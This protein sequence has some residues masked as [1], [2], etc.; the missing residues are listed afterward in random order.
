MYV[1]IVRAIGVEVA[2][3]IAAAG[4]R[5]GHGKS[6]AAHRKLSQEQVVG[7]GRG[8]DATLYHREAA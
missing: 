1:S 2:A 5:C 6:K 7:L 4:K 3:D 8:S